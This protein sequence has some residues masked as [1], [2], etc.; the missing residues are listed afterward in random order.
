MSIADSKVTFVI[1]EKLKHTRAG[2]HQKPLEYLAYPIDQKLCF[3]THEKKSGEDKVFTEL[4]NEKQSL[5]SCIRPHKEVSRDT[6]SQWIKNFMTAAGI[7]ISVYKSH[8]CS[9]YIIPRWEV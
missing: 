1:T 5:V 9:I 3:V 6:I 4:N 8:V 2:T 7:D